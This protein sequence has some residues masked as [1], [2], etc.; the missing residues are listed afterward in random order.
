VLHEELQYVVAC[1][2]VEHGLVQ[3][4]NLWAD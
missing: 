4:V 2:V 1:G 3:S